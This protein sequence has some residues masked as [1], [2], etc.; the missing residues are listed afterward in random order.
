MNEH[1]AELKD[2]AVYAE[3]TKKFKQHKHVYNPFYR[4]LFLNWIDAFKRNFNYK[5]KIFENL[6]IAK[7]KE[8]TKKA[9]YV[10]FE[11]LEDSDVAN[12]TMEDIETKRIR[13]TEINEEDNSL[14]LPSSISIHK[15]HIQTFQLFLSFRTM[16]IKNTENRFIF[17]IDIFLP[18]INIKFFQKNIRF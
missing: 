9:D 16:H 12:T 3:Q 7:K 5:S 13:N 8:N 18:I 14:I 10:E 17:A 2:P 15:R 11:D 1:R 6:Q 4:G